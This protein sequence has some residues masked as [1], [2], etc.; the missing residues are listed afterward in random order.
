[1]DNIILDDGEPTGAIVQRLSD[2]ET[3]A[4]M[5]AL[6]IAHARVWRNDPEAGRDLDAATRKIGSLIGDDVHGLEVRAIRRR[7]FTRHDP[8]Q[9]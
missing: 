2:E 6:S 7:V 8:S 4:L 1:M 9:W 3:A 5:D